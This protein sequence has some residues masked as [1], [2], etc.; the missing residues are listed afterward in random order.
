MH[1]CVEIWES[2]YAYQQVRLHEHVY[3]VH[4]KQ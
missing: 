1:K 2:E 4:V 3:F